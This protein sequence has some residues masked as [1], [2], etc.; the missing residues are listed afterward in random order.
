MLS[1]LFLEQIVQIVDVSLRTKLMIEIG[2]IVPDVG[3]EVVNGD[4][5]KSSI[6]SANNMIGRCILKSLE[7]VEE[8]VEVLVKGLFVDN[9]IFLVITSKIQTLENAIILQQFEN[10]R[11]CGS[12]FHDEGGML[13]GILLGEVEVDAVGCSREVDEL[14]VFFVFFVELINTKLFENLV[15]GH[16]DFS[17]NLSFINDDTEIVFVFD[18]HELMNFAVEFM[19]RVS[20]ENIVLNGH[21]HAILG[22]FDPL[23]RRVTSDNKAVL[24]RSGV[25][26]IVDEMVECAKHTP[27]FAGL[28]ESKSENR[29]H[30]RRLDELVGDEFAKFFLVEKEFIIVGGEKIG[31]VLNA[32]GIE[33]T[34]IGDFLRDSLANVHDFCVGIFKE[35]WDFQ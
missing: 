16:V 24:W 27:S 33:R 1:G 35:I 2:K 19:E 17:S 23:L 26:L 7:L 20:V 12:R 32:S 34:R 18:V 29:K 5:M 11:I 22:L 8:V 15:N 13:S 6:V 9:T 30:L 3:V 14:D 31:I 25:L 4:L 28:C 21:G 10:T